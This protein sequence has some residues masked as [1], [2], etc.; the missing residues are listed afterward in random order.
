[1]TLNLKDIALGQ[2]DRLQ[3]FYPR[4]EGKASF[5]FA[6]NIGMGG[7]LAA[8]LPFKKFL[9]HEA[10]PAWISL[11]LLAFS[12]YRLFG[13]F[14]PHLDGAK[15]KGLIYFGDIADLSS[16]DYIERMKACT[17]A[18]LEHDALCQV[19]RNSEI[20][21]KKYDRAKYAFQSTGLALVPWLLFLSIV[22]SSGTPPVLKAG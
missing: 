2:F 13:T 11:A 3:G 1:M 4:V 21:K 18:D 7:V 19:W 6:I 12:T 17:E 8:N 20:L 22:A 15:H 5:L 16:D 10:I 9:T 14:F